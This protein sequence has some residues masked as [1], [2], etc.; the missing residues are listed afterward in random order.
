[1]KEKRTGGFTLVE[2]I[3]VIVIVLILA[4]VL[5]PNVTK[6]I[7]SAREAR[8]RSEAM[9]LVNV[10]QNSAILEMAGVVDT[11]NRKDV[12]INGKNK[13]ISWI[14]TGYAEAIL[15]DAGAKPYIAIVGMGSTAAYTGDE[16]YR[17]HIVYFVAYQARE[18]EAPIFYNGKE[19]M[20]TY[21][22]KEAG[23]ADGDNLFDV[24]GEQVEL[25]FYYLAGPNET[26]I[27]ANWNKLKEMVEKYKE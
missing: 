7:K 24:G 10:M 18:T 5:V 21:P 8:A 25:Q 4:A 16:E 17:T 12:G 15:K 27:S 19:W 2:L 11:S 6:Y 20:H 3:V 26:N 23:K 13:D 9:N 22:W 1:M 14:G